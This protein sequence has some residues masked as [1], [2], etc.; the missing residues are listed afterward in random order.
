LVFYYILLS[1]GVFAPRQ[2]FCV[3][4]SRGST[5][6]NGSY[7]HNTV[8]VRV[9]TQTNSVLVIHTTLARPTALLPVLIHSISKRLSP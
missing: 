7:A 4:S 1:V 2:Q 6:Q 3:D 5:F 8:Y 9:R